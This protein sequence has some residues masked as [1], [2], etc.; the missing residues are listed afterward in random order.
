MEFRAAVTFSP[1]EGAAMHKQNHRSAA[2]TPR[3][4]DIELLTFIVAVRQ[5]ANDLHSGFGRMRQ[6]WGKRIHHE[7]HVVGHIPPPSWP[8]LGTQLSQLLGNNRCRGHFTPPETGSAS[9]RERVSP[10]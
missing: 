7:M 1:G 9:C 8:D 6:Q 4:I 2:G 3:C 5:V 10:Y